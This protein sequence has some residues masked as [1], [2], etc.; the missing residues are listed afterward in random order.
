MIVS[1]LEPI[2]VS[3]KTHPTKR[4][5]SH[6]YANNKKFIPVSHELRHNPFISIVEAAEIRNNSLYNYESSNVITCATC[7]ATV[8]KDRI[9]AG[10]HCWSCKQD[11]LITNSKIAQRINMV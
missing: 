11:P 6:K 10:G 2:W 3:N 1:S 9:N 5:N 7:W 4:L 8:S